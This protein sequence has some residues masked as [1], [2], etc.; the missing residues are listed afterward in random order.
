MQFKTQSKEILVA[1]DEDT[2]MTFVTDPDA[3][4]MVTF[5]VKVVE[6]PLASDP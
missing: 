1:T 6:V 5:K 4:G 3:G 2:L